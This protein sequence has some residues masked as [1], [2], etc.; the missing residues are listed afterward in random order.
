MVFVEDVENA[1]VWMLFDSSIFI[2]MDEYLF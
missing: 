1:L 2:K